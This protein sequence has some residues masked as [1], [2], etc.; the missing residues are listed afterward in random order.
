[1]YRNYPNKLDTPSRMTRKQARRDVFMTNKK[2]ARL[3]RK[4]A[5][6]ARQQAEQ[7]E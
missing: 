2:V 7:G 4:T 1:M 3:R 6:V 5:R